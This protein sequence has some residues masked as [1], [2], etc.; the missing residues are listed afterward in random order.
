MRAVNSSDDEDEA[1]TVVDDSMFNNSFNLAVNKDTGAITI[2]K[3]A[4]PSTDVDSPYVVGDHFKITATDVD[5]FSATT[6]VIKV[7]RNRAPVK[8]ESGRVVAALTDALVVGNQDKIQ[9][10][11]TNKEQTST[12]ACDVTD[13]DRLNVVC[14]SK[15]D[16]VLAFDADMDTMVTY[17]ARSKNPANASAEISSDGR[18]II[19]GHMPL[20]ANNAVTDIKVFLK[21]TDSGN[22]VSEE[23]EI[24]VR[25]DPKPVVGA[26]PT[27]LSVKATGTETMGMIRGV[28]SF[29]TDT[30]HLGAV[31]APTFTLV[32]SDGTA[33]NATASNPYFSAD[34][35]DGNLDITG[36][37]VTTSPIPLVILVEESGAAPNQWVKHTVM[38]SVVPNS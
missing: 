37:N 13:K 16:V 20:M 21:A 23:H 32:A 3:L 15:A 29:I 24:L 38:V 28:G 7:Q 11:S 9:L 1:G 33:P 5:G 30:D 18:L 12:D 36:N 19:T 26:L 4:T 34:I 14:I 27:A 31:E 17:S 25:V 35:S 6:D 10:D 22:L 2:T 8:N